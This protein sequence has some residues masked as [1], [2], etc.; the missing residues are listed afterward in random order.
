VVDAADFQLRAGRPTR[1]GSEVEADRRA[2]KSH[3]WREDQ[4]QDFDDRLLEPRVDP[5]SHKG[6]DR[7]DPK[8]H[9]Q[10]NREHGADSITPRFEVTST[11]DE[12]S[13]GRDGFRGGQVKVMYTLL[14][15]S[16]NVGLG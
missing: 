6:T 12:L 4:L 7:Y 15:T 16:G 8:K 9:C 13:C 5:D 3:Y 2:D 11:Y 14:V 10:T 1:A